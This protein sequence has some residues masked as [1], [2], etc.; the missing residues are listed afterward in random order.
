M[1]RWAVALP[2]ALAVVVAWGFVAGGAVDNFYIE[3]TSEAVRQ[4]ADGQRQAALASVVLVV[5]AGLV[6]FLRSRFPAAG[7]GLVGGGA[8]L[9]LVTS[10]SEIVLAT[11]LLSALPVG[12]GVLLA[13]VPAPSGE[14]MRA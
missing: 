3:N 1:S 5:L 12:L 8:V 9:V 4:G 7:A 11:G 10:Q 6:P 13:L 2:W 14:T